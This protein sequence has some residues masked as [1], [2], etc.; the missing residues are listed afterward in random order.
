MK[1][2]KN[3]LWVSTIGILISCGTSK[4][5]KHA[6]TTDTETNRVTQQRKTP[7]AIIS[8]RILRFVI[9]PKQK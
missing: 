4:Q 1:T 6:S 5:T 3:L 8:I 2:I 9:K 7:S